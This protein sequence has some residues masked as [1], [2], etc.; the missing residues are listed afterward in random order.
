ML[1]EF[2]YIK[3]EDFDKNNSILKEKKDGTFDVD[4]VLVKFNKQLLTSNINSSNIPDK[5][6]LLRML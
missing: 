3:Q 4:R 6:F 5:S 1:I 2:K